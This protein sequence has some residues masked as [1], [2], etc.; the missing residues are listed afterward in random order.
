MMREC[1]SDLIYNS[2][3]LI[4]KCKQL[5]CERIDDHTANDLNTAIDL[6]RKKF[7]VS[8]NEFR[9]KWGVLI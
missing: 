4:V 3:S 9:T 6:F 5:S 1:K 7:A 8:P 2:G